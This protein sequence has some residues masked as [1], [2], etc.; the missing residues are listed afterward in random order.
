MTLQ[1]APTA[2]PGR[3]DRRSLGDVGESIVA[4][5]LTEDGTQILD[6]NWRCAEGELDIV[7]QDAE[8]VLIGVEVKTRRGLGYGEPLEAV[9]PSKVARLRRLIGVWLRDHPGVDVVDI[10][11]DVVGVLIQ[12]DRVTLRHVREVGS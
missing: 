4:R 1:D 5:Y 2:S 8:G 11:L 3:D 6:R 10:R 9:T 7:A 12:R